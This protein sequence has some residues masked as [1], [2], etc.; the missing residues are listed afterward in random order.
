MRLYKIIIALIFSLLLSSSIIAQ[1]SN[2]PDPPG[3]HGDSDNLPP[4]GSAPID[5]GLFILISLGAAYG[6]RKLYIL[7]EEHSN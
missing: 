2:P 7:K 5:G 3:T 4:G 6:G 1:D